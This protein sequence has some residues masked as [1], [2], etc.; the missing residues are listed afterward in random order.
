MKQLNQDFFRAITDNNVEA[1]KFYIRLGAD[2]NVKNNYGYTALMY[3]SWNGYTE[4]V[5]LLL[6]TSVDVNVKDM[7]NQ[8]ALMIAS[9]N[10]HTELVTLLKQ[11][12]ARE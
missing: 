9:W 5:K 11:H 10:G 7:A 8:T 3:A 6:A 2:V 4:I 12:G 1:A